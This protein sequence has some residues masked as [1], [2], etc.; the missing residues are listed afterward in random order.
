MFLPCRLAELHDQMAIKSSRS[1]GRTTEGLSQP[2]QNLRPDRVSLP[3]RHPD[4]PPPRSRRVRG[5]AGPEDPPAPA[6][7]WPTSTTGPR[8]SPTTWPRSTHRSAY[9]PART[10]LTG[11]T[12]PLPSRSTR[13]WPAAVVRDEPTPG[14]GGTADA[15]RGAS[16]PPCLRHLRKDGHMGM[17]SAVVAQIGGQDATRLTSSR[18]TMVRASLSRRGGR[19]AAPPSHRRALRGRQGAVARLVIRPSSVGVMVPNPMMWSR[20]TSAM[21]SRVTP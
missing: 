11:T 9:G 1:S 5:R 10:P 20:T 4:P 18:V 3:H 14:M 7:P 17:Y 21:T 8:S 2:L 6:S 12:G 13:T 19:S 15:A 16:A